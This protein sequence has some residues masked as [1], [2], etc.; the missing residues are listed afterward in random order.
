MPFFVQLNIEKYKGRICLEKKKNNGIIYCYIIKNSEKHAGYCCIGSTKM[1]IE[2]RLNLLF[3]CSALS[4]TLIWTAQASYVNGEEI[5]GNAF[6]K[7]LR[8][9]GYRCVYDEWFAI[10]PYEALAKLREFRSMNNAI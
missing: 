9:S 3:G 4:P 2:D 1:S 7:Y 8:E 10:N 6:R 5:T